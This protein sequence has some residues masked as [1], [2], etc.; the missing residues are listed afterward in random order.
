ML[1][2]KID[3]NADDI[4]AAVVQAIAQSAIGQ[5]LE[6]AIQATLEKLTK[7]EYFRHEYRSTLERVVY[8]LTLQE[9]RRVVIEQ[10]TEPTREA[11]RRQLSNAVINDL[12]GKAVSLSIE[13]LT[14]D[15]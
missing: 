5:E 9:I 2:L 8:D 15:R 13:K 6:K 14:E 3:L 4:Q 11:V 1:P 10:C 12:V 7:P